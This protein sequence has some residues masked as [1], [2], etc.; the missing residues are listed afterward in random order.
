MRSSR[1]SGEIPGELRTL[2]ESAVFASS[3]QH[4]QEA[5]DSGRDGQESGQTCGNG[6]QQ[7]NDEAF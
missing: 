3:G 4:M 7:A 6:C 1:R 5:Y 2:G